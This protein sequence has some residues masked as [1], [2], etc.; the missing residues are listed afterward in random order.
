MKTVRKVILIYRKVQK[1]CR[2]Y[3]RLL[4]RAEQLGNIAILTA[5]SIGTHELEVLFSSSMIVVIVIGLI[6]EEEA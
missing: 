3:P 6:G 5:V 4:H 2:R 1:G